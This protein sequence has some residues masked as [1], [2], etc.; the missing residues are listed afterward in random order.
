GISG[1][2]LNGGTTV[3][4][5]MILAHRAGI[6][7]FATG[8]LGGVHRHGENSMDISADLTELGRTPVAVI[9]SGCKSF[10]DIPRTLEYLE[11]QGVGVS[12]FADGRTGNVDFPAFLTR[13]SGVK[14]P[15]VVRDEKEAAA[16]T[17]AQT[18]LQLSSG[19]LFGNPIPLKYSLA[20]SRMDAIMTEA[21]RSA[22]QHGM[23]GSDNTPFILGKIREL[24][25]GDTVAANRALVESNVLRGTKVAVELSKLELRDHSV[26]ARTL[27]S[28]SSTKIT[29]S[30]TFRS[31]KDEK[32]D[33]LVAGSLAI[34]LS[35]DYTPLFELSTPKEAYKPA[36]RTSNPAFI[37]QSLGGVGHNVATALHHLGTP[38]SLCSAVGEDA[39]GSTAKNKLIE[40]GMRI[41]AIEII[42]NGSRTAQYVAFNDAA[43]DLIIAMADMKILEDDSPGGFSRWKAHLHRCQP[44]WLVLDA[45]WHTSMLREWVTAG[46]SLGAKI[47]FEPVSSEKSVR[48][49]VCI[50]N[51]LEALLPL[52]DLAAPNEFELLAMSNYVR[53]HD[54]FHC[55]NLLSM[56]TDSA[57]P[58]NLPFQ[59]SISL[60]RS[61]I[62]YSSIA[63]VDR[64]VPQNVLAL[65]PFI[66]C[67]LTKLGSEGVLFTELLYQG[68]S[69]LTL[70]EEEPYIFGRPLVEYKGGINALAGIYMRLYP[71]AETVTP[72]QIVSVNGVGDTFLGVIVAGLAKENPKPLRELIEIAQRGAIMTLKSREPVSPDI[73]SLRSAL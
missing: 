19:L 9:S 67:I 10:L 65:L 51:P 45:N 5:T 33:V 61:L 70:Q 48:L 22:E 2:K 64:Q 11:T 35:C 59:Y 55:P 3:A 32:V 43:K 44:K 53:K 7:V 42:P 37:S 14:S 39:A 25:C 1:R 71:P 72:D 27:N 66:P 50:S 62:R 28:S 60:G 63:L 46:K 24:T 15:T 47:A 21:I 4:G 38:V 30:N 58:S 26:L 16:I 8:G 12:T 6:K 13:E 57:N 73:S 29:G 68:D 36:L 40:N 31:P 34:D 17:Y 41:D 69:R 56:M 52:V 20:K 23:S 18:S 49:F 54:E